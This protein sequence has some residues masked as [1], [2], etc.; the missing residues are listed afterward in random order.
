MK[1]AVFLP[2]WIGDVVMATPAI[3]AL[4]ARHPD[5]KMVAVGRDYVRD[6]VAGSPW[7][8]EFIPLRRSPLSAL[9]VA[10]RIRQLRC[11]S[12]VMFPN[13]FRVAAIAAAAGCRRRIGYSRY[14][15]GF[16][17]TDRFE[18]LRNAKGG[19]EPT[20]ILRDYNRLVEPLDARPT[21]VMELYTITTDDRVAEDT[22]AKLNIRADDEVIGIN[23]GAAFGA[24][25][26]WPIESFAELSRKFADQR[27]AKVLVLCGPSEK[28]I[29]RQIVEKSSRTRIQTVA[30]FPLSIGLTKAIVSR[31][32]LLV[33]TDSGPRHFAAAFNR[34]VVT[35]F[36]PTHIGWTETFYAKAVHLQKKVPCGPCQLRVCPLD[37][38]CMKELGVAEVFESSLGL[39]QKF[40]RGGLRHAG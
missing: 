12:A 14:G 2:N 10:K 3:A 38:R 20:P 9:Q 31:L 6:V 17:L 13:S 5:S 28:A 34:P 27:G 32:D 19:Y 37:H 40:G 11:D 26:F 30:D 23:P 24:S 25:K 18:A 39:L 29:A 8:D 7:F 15:R 35:L 36:G 33:T 4:K 1:I 16:L 22:L 21:D